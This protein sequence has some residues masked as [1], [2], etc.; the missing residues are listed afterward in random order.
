MEYY[1]LIFLPISE[2]ITL[3]VIPLSFLLP[4]KSLNLH[5]P[6][7]RT[8][9]AQIS[10]I[11]LE[12]LQSKFTFSFIFFFFF[13]STETGNLALGVPLSHCWWRS[14]AGWH[15][16]SATAEL[17]YSV[18]SSKMCFKQTKQG[19]ILQRI[20]QQQF[21]AEVN[22]RK[23]DLFFQPLPKRKICIKYHMNWALHR[24][25]G[26]AMWKMSGSNSGLIVVCSTCP[27]RGF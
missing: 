20:L 2:W 3:W 12:T 4:R 11:T 23:F 13:S 25:V 17:K 18:P 24:L 7:I 26:I 27:D 5:F 19:K 8:H 16:P 1:I 22:L 9:W 15:L 6:Q 21:E 14:T 10:C